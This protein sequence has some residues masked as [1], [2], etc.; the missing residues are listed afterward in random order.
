MSLSQ[1]IRIVTADLLHPWTSE[2]DFY[3]FK[4]KIQEYLTVELHGSLILSLQ[5][6]FYNCRK[7]ILLTQCWSL[8]SASYSVLYRSSAEPGNILIKESKIHLYIFKPIKGYIWLCG[9]LINKSQYFLPFLNSWFFSLHV[10][11]F[12]HS[13]KEIQAWTKQ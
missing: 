12:E 1:N 6:S 10:L 7:E 4:G 3:R 5:Y 9:A 8:L 13:D 11:Y 2:D